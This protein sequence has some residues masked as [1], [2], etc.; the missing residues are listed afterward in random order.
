MVKFR[1]KQSVCVVLLTVM[2]LGCFSACQNTPAASN[3]TTAQTEIQNEAGN[4]PASTVLELAKDKKTDFVITY[5][6]FANKS[7]IDAVNSMAEKFKSTTRATIKTE[8]ENAATSANMPANEIIVG[9]STREEFADFFAGL[10][11]GEYAIEVRGSKILIGGNTTFALLDAIDYF[12]EKI[13]TSREPTVAAD[14]SYHH[15]PT[16]NVSSIKLDDKDISEWKIVYSA[17]GTLARSIA[18]NDLYRYIGTA[19]G[20]EM[21][22][23]VYRPG[24]DLTGCIVVGETV[25]HTVTTKNYGD[26]HVYTQNGTI[27]VDSGDIVGLETGVSYLASL[28]TASEDVS[29]V[30]SEISYSESLLE[31][32]EYILDATKFKACYRFVHSVSAEELTLDHKIKLLNDPKGRTMIIAHRS[33]HTYY[34]ENSLEAVISAWLCGA[35][36]AEVDIRKTKDGHWICMHD[37]DLTRTTNVESMKGRN[38]LPNSVSVEDWTLVELRQLRLIDSYGQLTPFLIPTLEEVLIACDDKIFVHLDKTFNWVNDIFPI[39]EKVGV[40]ECVYLVNNIDLASTLNLCDYFS[41]KG[42]KLH[43]MTRTWSTSETGTTALSLLTNSDVITPAIIPL[44]DYEKWTKADIAAIRSYVGKLRIGTWVLRDY[45][46]E[47]IWRETQSN[48]CNILL[49]DYPIVL[50]NDIKA[51]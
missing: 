20:K 23:E 4:K 21:M 9:E 22:L 18:A 7:T 51:H 17:A 36:A 15:Q 39:M 16:Y 45:D 32:Y 26:C 28:L 44:G 50:L 11:Y 25:D 48:G 13:L 49:T 27:Y 37:E 19:C 43:S 40:Y 35:D 34:P 14:F 5:N 30:S 8:I 29:L 12:F 2:L 38:G 3:G 41:S 47:Y 46:Y 42:I 31:R 10:S 33:E 24:I 6:N 1:I